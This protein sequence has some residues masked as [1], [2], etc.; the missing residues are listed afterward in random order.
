MWDL[1]DVSCNTQTSPALDKGLLMIGT[2]EV[3]AIPAG[4]EV[5]HSHDAALACLGGEIWK[6]RETCVLVL[7]ADEAQADVTFGLIQGVCGRGADRH[8]E[9]LLLLTLNNL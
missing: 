6:L 2:I 5:V 3:L 7:E 4:W 8:A 1:S 9:A